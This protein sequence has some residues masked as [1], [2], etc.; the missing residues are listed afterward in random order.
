MTRQDLHYK[1]AF[2]LKKRVIF[3]FSL[4][5]IDAEIERYDC[6]FHSK[7]RIRHF[8]KILAEEVLF[9]Y[10]FS[11]ILMFSFSLKNII[12]YIVYDQLGILAKHLVQIHNF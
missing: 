5:K 11:N 12:A 2:N 9:K 8:A 4:I 6:N 1:V 10:Y 7:A 3:C